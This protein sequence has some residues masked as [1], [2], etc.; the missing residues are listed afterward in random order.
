VV[1]NKSLV[2]ILACGIGHVE[3]PLLTLFVCWLAAKERES[4]ALTRFWSD[5]MFNYPPPSSHLSKSIIKEE[6][7]AKTVRVSLIGF[8][9][10]PSVKAK[11]LHLLFSSTLCFLHPFR[12]LITHPSHRIIYPFQVSSFSIVSVT[13][14]DLSDISLIT[15]ACVRML[16]SSCINIE[17]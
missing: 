2:A 5:S 1:W 16:L 9:T 7:N 17:W 10:K 12:P 6:K 8:C 15:N 13:A 4:D 14:F 3:N 11:P